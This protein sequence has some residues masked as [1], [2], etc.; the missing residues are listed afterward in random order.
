[1]SSALVQQAAVYAFPLAMVYAVARDVAHYE[2]PNWLSVAIVI[3]FLILALWA[4]MRLSSIAWHLSVGGAVLVA[5][6]FL[7]S[8]GVIGGGDAK[9][10]AASTV[11]VG[12]PGLPVYLLA[13]ALLGGVL[14]VALLVLRRFP[15][16]ASWQAKVW[17]RSLHAREE[18]VPYCVAIG[19]AGL[20][21]FPNLPLVAH[22]AARLGGSGI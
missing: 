22:S 10:L 13:V 14:A 6:W 4:G 3:I 7:F 16:P 17:I 5:G 20:W 21:M 9:L 11:W 1:M 18:G 15:V 12:W 2:V 8:R 19:L